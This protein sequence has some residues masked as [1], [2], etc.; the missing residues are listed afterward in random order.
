MRI[1]TVQA[2]VQTDQAIFIYVM[3]YNNCVMLSY[4]SG[5]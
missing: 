5:A 2:M 4:W 3:A 1:K